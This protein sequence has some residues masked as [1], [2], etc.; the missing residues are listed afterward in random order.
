MT[1]S[2]M[3]RRWELIRS[4]PGPELILFHTRF[5]WYKNPRNGKLFKRV[6]LEAPDWVNVVALTPDQRIILVRQFRF[7]VGK[8]TTEIPAGII[9]PGEPPEQ[10]ARRELEEETGYTTDQWEYLGWIQPNPAFLDNHCHTFLARNVVKTHPPSPDEGEDIVVEEMTV[11]EIHRAIQSGSIRNA[12]AVV[13]L[14]H[15][16]DLRGSW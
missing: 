3:D 2:D 13:A 10:A 8:E 12:L 4:E 14:S 7:G 11:E 5:D 9:E 15:V 6:A 16:F 1:D